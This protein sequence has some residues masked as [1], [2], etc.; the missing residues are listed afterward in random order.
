MTITL[1]L[2]SGTVAA[3][4]R[5][6]AYE[7]ADDMTVGDAMEQA[8]NE[9][10]RTLTDNEKENLVFLINSRPSGWGSALSDGDQLRV[11]Y[12]VLGG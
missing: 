1:K 4:L 11:M 8:Q 9:A 6:G 2:A 5:E 12:K 7:L 3:G 10:G